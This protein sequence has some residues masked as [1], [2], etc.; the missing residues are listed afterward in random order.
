MTDEETVARGEKASGIDARYASRADL[1]RFQALRS[2][3]L[4]LTLSEVTDEDI[5][6]F[7]KKVRE[8][9]GLSQASAGKVVQAQAAVQLSLGGRY[10]APDAVRS[11]PEFISFKKGK[12]EILRFLV[13]TPI[14]DM[15]KAAERVGQT[16]ITAF[17]ELVQQMIDLEQILLFVQGDEDVK[18]PFELTPTIIETLADNYR[19]LGSGTQT[20]IR[21]VSKDISI[22]SE[23]RRRRGQTNNTP[24]AASTMITDHARR[25]VEILASHS[26]YLDHQFEQF[27]QHS[28]LRV[29][30]DSSRQLL[31]RRS[32]EFLKAW[33]GLATWGLRQ[34]FL[35]TSR[36]N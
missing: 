20:R 22:Y 30:L 10:S 4:R 1:A 2:Q 18:Q 7:R 29:V 26:Y 3:E 33:A 13:T 14:S 6:I 21:Q 34:T 28:E 17:D 9:T 31:Q 35:R 19:R 15:R 24:S 16:Y 23:A 32:V 8:F 12:G 27:A 25:L 5:E 36:Q 11:K